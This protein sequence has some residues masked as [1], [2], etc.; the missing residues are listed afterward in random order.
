MSH[1]KRCHE[2]LLVF[3]LFG[4][5]VTLY[6]NN[7]KSKKKSYFGLVVSVLMFFLVS[8]YVTILAQRIGNPE[9]QHVIQSVY[10]IDLNKEEELMRLSEQDL[11]FFAYFYKATDQQIQLPDLQ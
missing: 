8:S 3:D 5:P 9:N 6:Y 4:Y 7:D 1:K 10:N 11:R 2:N